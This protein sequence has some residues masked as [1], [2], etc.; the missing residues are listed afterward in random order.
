MKTATRRAIQRIASSITTS[1][2][3]TA[4]VVVSSFSE[5]SAAIDERVKLI[6]VANMSTVTFTSRLSIAYQ[7][8]IRG[9]N[10]TLE[11]NGGTSLFFV[12]PDGSL[13][14]TGLTVRDCSNSGNVSHAQVLQRDHCTQRSAFTPPFLSLCISQSGGAISTYFGNLTILDSVFMHNLASYVSV[15]CLLARG[16][17]GLCLMVARVSRRAA[18]SEAIEVS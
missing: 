4:T 11:G 16:H 12:T 18:H 17:H 8:T 10:A 13:T 7:V 15:P 9:T 2:A 6:E 5:L 3:P 14:L 1:V